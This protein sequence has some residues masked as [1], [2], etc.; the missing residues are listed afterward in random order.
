MGFTPLPQTTIERWFSTGLY[1]ALQRQIT[2]LSNML[3]F[4]VLD[5]LAVAGG[6]AIVTAIVRAAYAATRAWHLVPVFRALGNL[7]VSAALVYLAFLT[8]WGLNYRRVPIAERLVVC[9]ASR[10]IMSGSRIRAI[11]NV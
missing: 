4:A 1:P 3:P 11:P 9:A 10:R 6:A 5:V 8:L 2:P 7:G